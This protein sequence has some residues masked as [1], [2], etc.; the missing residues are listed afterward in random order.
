MK[1]R[2]FSTE[3]ELYDSVANFM[4]GEIADYVNGSLC[5]NVN[6]GSERVETGFSILKQLI[7][8]LHDRCFITDKEL[9]SLHKRLANG[10]F[11]TR[12]RFKNRGVDFK[13]C[14]LYWHPDGKYKGQE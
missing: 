8:D 9:D 13:F 11:A 14:G 7:L 2:T 5:F 3:N 4:H 6:V 10:Y 12:E 1:P